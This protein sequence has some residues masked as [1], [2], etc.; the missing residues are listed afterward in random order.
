MIVAAFVKTS[1]LQLV[2]M[3]KLT[4]HE[5]DNLKMNVAVID[6]SHMKIK[7]SFKDLFCEN[8]L[9]LSCKMFMIAIHQVPPLIRVLVQHIN[10]IG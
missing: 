5:E 9:A 4:F 6:A 8:S 3:R 2:K 7:Q 1:Q 10:G